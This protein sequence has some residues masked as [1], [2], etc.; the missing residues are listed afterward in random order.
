[1]HHVNPP[2]LLGHSLLDPAS[3][4]CPQAVELFLADRI[5]YMDI[6]PVV[7]AC[8]EAHAAHLVTAPS[9]EEIVHYDAW[10][11]R[12]VAESVSATESKGLAVAA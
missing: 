10:A 7:E 12:H 5:G 1:M 2:P 3:C 6:I 11:R 9:L 4:A 8:C